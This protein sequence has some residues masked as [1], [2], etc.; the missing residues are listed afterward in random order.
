MHPSVAHTD[1]ATMTQTMA[2]NFA[3]MIAAHPQDWHM[4]QRLWRAD[5]DT[6]STLPA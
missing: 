4:F 6:R 3:A 2:D 5:L 1:I